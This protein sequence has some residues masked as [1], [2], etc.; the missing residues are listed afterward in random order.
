MVRLDSPL[1]PLGRAQFSQRLGRAL[2]GDA[3]EVGRLQHHVAPHLGTEY[4]TRP[5][6]MPDTRSVTHRDTQSTPA[7]G[8]SRRH[9][10]ETK[11]S[12]QTQQISDCPLLRIRAHIMSIYHK[13]FNHLMRRAKPHTNGNEQY[14]ISIPGVRQLVTG[15]RPRFKR[16][17][18]FVVRPQFRLESKVAI[19]RCKLG[20]GR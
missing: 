20:D 15:P 1:C 19:S 16:V 12:A 6:A 13:R 7:G 14:K 9:S 3:A 11:H 17:I 10:P 18:R 5:P 4:I 2:D 8:T